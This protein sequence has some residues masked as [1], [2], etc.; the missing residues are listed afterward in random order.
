MMLPAISLFF[1]L[2]ALS[3]CGRIAIKDSYWCADAGKFGAECFKLNSGETKSLD[4]FQWDRLRVGQICS[5]TDEPGKAYAEIKAALLK[6]CANTNRCTFEEQK[7]INL[8]VARMD[9]A[10]KSVDMLGAE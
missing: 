8:A 4:K 9:R 6:L 5:G 1:T 2:A 3:G 10:I 7:K